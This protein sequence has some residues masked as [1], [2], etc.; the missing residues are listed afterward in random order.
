MNNHVIA[1]SEGIIFTIFFL[2]AFSI[3]FTVSNF[4]SGMNTFKS[5]IFIFLGLVQF[6]SFV[7]SLSICIFDIL[8]IKSFRSFF[9]YQELFF[10]V[11]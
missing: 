2:I 1:N 11:L 9:L 8:L 5:E 6:K 7:D 4:D 10:I 3:Y